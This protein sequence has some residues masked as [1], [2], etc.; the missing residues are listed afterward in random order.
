[1]SHTDTVPLAESSSAA[2]ETLRSSILDTRPRPTGEL[3][4]SV[5]LR[6]GMLA[7][8]RAHAP[9]LN[10][11][12]R[13]PANVDATRVSMDLHDELIHVMVTM[14]MASN[15]FTATERGAVTI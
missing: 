13:R 8:L 12:H 6:Q 7:W 2:Y 9:V 4:L 1:M 11:P 14:A 5:L 15:G 10:E 3:G